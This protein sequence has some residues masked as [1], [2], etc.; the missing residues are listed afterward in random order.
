ANSR[1][2]ATWGRAR[3]V[4]EAARR[5]GSIERRDR[6][7]GRLHRPESHCRDGIPPIPP[8]DLPGPGRAWLVHPDLTGLPHDQWNQL[9]TQLRAARELQREKDL[10][11]RRGGDRQKVPAAGLYTGRR[12]GLTLVDRTLA[13]F[14]YHRHALPQVAVARLFAVTPQTINRAIRKT[15]RLLDEIGHTIEP[16]T[17][18]LTTLDD[19]ADLATRLGISPTPK[20]KTAS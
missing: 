14:L 16:A 12:P 1:A 2:T 10:H 5:N 6:A 8:Q 9:I 11:Q 3:R 19:L 7:S 4:R 18:R 15:H 20:I 13:T 17:T